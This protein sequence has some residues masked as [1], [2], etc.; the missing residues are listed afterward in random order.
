MKPLGGQ[1]KK[2]GEIAV[3]DVEMMHRIVMKI[4][5]RR[6]EDYAGR[7]IMQEGGL[8]RKEDYVGRGTM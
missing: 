2:V 5:L 8:C 7:R 6:K 3:K 1:R 4:G